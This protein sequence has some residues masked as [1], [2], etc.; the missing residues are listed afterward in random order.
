MS[1]SSPSC[2]HSTAGT[3]LHTQAVL[4]LS[5]SHQ[6]WDRSLRRKQAKEDAERVRAK[7][8]V[9]MQWA[10]SYNGK[11]GASH[12]LDVLPLTEYGFSFHKGAFQDALALRYGWT[13]RHVPSQCACGKHFT[14]EHTFNCPYGGFPSLRHND[15]NAHNSLPPQWSVLWWYYL[16]AVVNATL[17]RKAQ[18]QDSQHWGWCTPGHPS[19]R[20]LRRKSS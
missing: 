13:P 15:I 14:M 20:I 2:S 11:K 10:M 12:W 17:R 18:A 4:Q 9:E 5:R 1:D 8:P 7:P 3:F 16:G 6:E 19:T